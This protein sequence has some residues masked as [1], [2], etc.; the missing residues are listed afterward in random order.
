MGR[1]GLVTMGKDN[2]HMLEDLSGRTGFAQR[3]CL[4]SLMLAGL[5]LLG[6][7]ALAASCQQIRAELANFNSSS[8]KS[9]KARQWEQARTAQ[10][11][12]IDAVKR[13][14]KYLNCQADADPR[15]KG[16][17][18]KLKRMDANLNKLTRQ[19][20]RVAGLS[21]S[22]L[23]RKKALESQ[24][25]SSGCTA[26][27][28]RKTN[29]L[30]KLFGNKST[31][32]VNGADSG[33]KLDYVTTRNGLVLQRPKATVSS[34]RSSSGLQ[35][36]TSNHSLGTGRDT[37]QRRVRLPRGGTFRTMCVRTCDGYF[38][39]VSFATPQ[40]QFLN[41]EARCNEMCPAS[42]TELFVYQN[43]G[44]TVENMTSVAGIPYADTENAYRFRE[45]FVPNCQCRSLNVEARSTSDIQSLAR[46][47]D[48]GSGDGALEFHSERLDN[49]RIRVTLRPSASDIYGEENAAN[50]AYI[51]WSRPKVALEDLPTDE[52][53]TT[54]MDLEEGFNALAT[55]KPAETAVEEDSDTLAGKPK[56]LPLLTSKVKPVKQEATPVFAGS[57]DAPLRE[58]PEQ[59]VR[60]VGPKYFVAQ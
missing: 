4:L 19:L 26:E 13:D 33:K 1:S 23:R 46:S 12:A 52:D 35:E 15:C 25:Q 24:L 50:A 9:P 41:D 3:F 47:G 43:P 53:P 7:P 29:V 17:K 39:P 48:G 6:D 34:S 8:V 2:R 38:F 27:A 36:L 42:Q 44:G 28:S 32:T 56:A 51:D 11:T 57:N 22:D 16:L 49:N 5:L 37:Y 31:A 18:S 54:L 45:E 14:M 58:A 10:R 55:V 21:K 60:V 30:T 20:G 40:N 59:N